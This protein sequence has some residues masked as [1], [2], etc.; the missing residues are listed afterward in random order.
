MGVAFVLEEWTLLDEGDSGWGP[1][2]G[3]IVSAVKVSNIVW[4]LMKYFFVWNTIY[5]QLIL[6]SYDFN[7]L[8]CLSKILSETATTSHDCYVHL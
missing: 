6:N 3:Q 4:I 5:I 1:L 2:S 7:L 8:G